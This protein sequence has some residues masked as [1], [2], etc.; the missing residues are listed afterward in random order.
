MDL[1]YHHEF[2][3]F[4]LLAAWD[5]H[6]DGLSED[7]LVHKQLQE[8]HEVRQI[9]NRARPGILDGHSTL[10]PVVHVAFSIVDV[11]QSSSF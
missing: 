3:S 11:C 9:H 6:I 10:H 1:S 5:A 4:Q 2:S 8:Q 7:I